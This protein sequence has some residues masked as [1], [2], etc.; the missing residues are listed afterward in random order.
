MPKK[1]NKTAQN[2]YLEE[3]KG[4]VLDDFLEK[5]WYRMGPTIFSS[6]YI[7]YKNELFS[8]IWLRTQLESYQNTK[9]LKKLNRKNRA[10]LTHK[11]EKFQYT[12]ELEAL[13]QKY[14]VGFKG[15][16]PDTLA[17]YMMDSLSLPIYD[18]C[19]LSVYH[20]DTL[21][22]CSI[23]DLGEKTLASIFGFYDPVYSNYSLG[24]Y[25]MLLEIAYGQEQDMDTYYVGYFVP[26]NP[27]FD[28]KLRLGGVEYLDF[29]TREWYNIAQFDYE[30]TPINIISQKLSSLQSSLKK[31]YGATLYQNAFIDVHIIEYFPM[32]YLDDPLFLIF[33]GLS[34]Y[35]SEENIVVITYD[36]QA[37]AYKL[38]HCQILH[39]VFSNYNPDWLKGLDD[40]TFKYQMVIKKT[41]K[42]CK[43]V[44]PIVKF[45]LEQK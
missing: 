12:A 36:V 45:F 2:L 10:A 1:I 39:A 11:V 29:K 19:L 28:Y 20:D 32:R 26:G 35:K 23:F 42:T 15:N 33:E 25:T 16:L 31:E 5:G 37:A 24:L 9:S 17:S 6:F 44:K 22:A 38:Y 14:R 18:T 21:I 27:R 13:Y 7:F 40:E 8:T 30:K 43:T 34:S 41:L 4:P 3:I